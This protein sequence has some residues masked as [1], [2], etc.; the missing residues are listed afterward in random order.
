V[1][2]A[3]KHIQDGTTPAWTVDWGRDN[4][5]KFRDFLDKTTGAIKREWLNE[6]TYYLGF[7]SEEDAKEFAQLYLESEESKVNFGAEGY[8][9]YPGLVKRYTKE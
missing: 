3:Y 2:L 8:R 1:S 7:R 4:P 9:I 5:N 6:K